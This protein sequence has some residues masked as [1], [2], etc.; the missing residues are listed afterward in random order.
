[1]AFHT[2]NEIRPVQ[3]V[4]VVKL[5]ATEFEGMFPIPLVLKDTTKGIIAVRLSNRH[6]VLV[7]NDT[8]IAQMIFKE[9]MID[10]DIAIHSDITFFSKD[11]FKAYIRCGHE[12]TAV[13]TD[14]IINEVA[15]IFG[16]GY[17]TVGLF[18]DWN[19]LQGKPSG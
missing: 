19:I 2:S 8:D 1:M 4:H 5:L 14:T 3:S 11:V 16:G 15:A 9:I 13:F 12:K 6:T 17:V 10:G 18:F 7:H